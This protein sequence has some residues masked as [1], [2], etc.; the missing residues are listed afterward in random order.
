MGEPGFNTGTG[1]S[2]VLPVFG[3]SF[4]MICSPKLMYHAIPS[5]S[6]ITSCG[7]RVGLGRS[8]SVMITRVALPE[9]RGKVF[10]EEGH[11]EDLLKLM[12]LRNSPIRC[13]FCAWRLW[14]P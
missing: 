14:P 6:S 10:S 4:P 12:L 8:Y 2:V 9:G 13:R 5:E 3:S 11:V 1:N 7:C